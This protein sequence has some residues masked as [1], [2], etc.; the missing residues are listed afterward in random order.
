MPS[1]ILTLPAKVLS[2][3]LA[4]TFIISGT[5][6]LVPWHPMHQEMLDKAPHWLA[7]LRL[8]AFGF[9]ADTL[10]MSIGGAELV[11]GLL[12][13]LTPAA[14]YFLAAIMGGAIATHYVLDDNTFTADVIPAVF[15]SV[16]L[17]IH[18]FLHGA[19]RAATKAE[20]KAELQAAAVAK[21]D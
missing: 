3:F 15:L 14:G 1:S 17:G 8:S 7:A 12:L 10:R 9:D 21:K 19:I 20:K 5:G 11:F 4:F 18:A 13:L 2:F 6:K 16:L